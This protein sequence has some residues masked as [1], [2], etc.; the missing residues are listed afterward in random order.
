MAARNCIE[1][2]IPLTL[3]DGRIVP[4]G[5]CKLT[6]DALEGHAN[7]AIQR[8]DEILLSFVISSGTHA[9]ESTARVYSVTHAHP[10]EWN[11]RSSNWFMAVPRAAD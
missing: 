1:F 9:T 8:G 6:A 11:G 10:E 7:E 3:G 5:Y 2:A 4:T